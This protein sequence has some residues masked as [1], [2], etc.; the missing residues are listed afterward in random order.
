MAREPAQAL[1]LDGELEI[2]DVIVD[3]DGALGR[4]EEDSSAVRGPFDQLELNFELLAPKSRSFDGP[5]D[6]LTIL[7]DDANLLT[8]W[9][10]AHVSDDTLVPVVD[11]LFEPVLLVKHPD[12]DETLFI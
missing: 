1:D 12:N 5:D 10:P 3:V 8:V 4:A 7:I 9:R 6:D 11:H 2:A